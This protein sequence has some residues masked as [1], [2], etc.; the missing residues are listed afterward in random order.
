MFHCEQL[1]CPTAKGVNPDLENQ[2]MLALRMVNMG[3]RR[4]IEA[5]RNQ[6]GLDAAA[7]TNG[8]VLGYLSE[9][10]NEDVYQR[11]LEKELG[12]CRSGVSKIVAALEKEGLIERSRVASDDRLKKIVLTERG[13][14]YTGQIREDCRRLEEMLTSGFTDEESAQL[15]AYLQKMQQ[16][17]TPAI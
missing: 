2:T 16:N 9:H 8:W 13:R 5:F 10:E 11:D 12:I 3:I 14:T 17:L 1:H 7:G 15:Q 6:H 4:Q